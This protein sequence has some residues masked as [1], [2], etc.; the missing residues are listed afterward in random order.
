MAPTLDVYDYLDYR[1]FLRAYYEAKKAEGRGFSYRS[2]AR[3]A[4]V[5]APNHLKLVIEAQRNLAPETAVAYAEALA[6]QG[7]RG[8]YFVELVRFNQAKTSAERNAA[9]DRLTGF[10]GY[11]MAHKLDLAHAAYHAS[12]YVPAIRELA[13]REDFQAD[14]KWIAA[15]MVPAITA[16]EAK[17]ALDT[18]FELGLLEKN[19]QGRVVQGE[20]VMATGPETQGL[21]IANYHRA[22]LELAAGSIDRVHKT[23]RDISSLTMAVGPHDLH[24]LKRR[25]QRFQQELIAFA[26]KVEDADRVVQLNFQLFPLSRGRDE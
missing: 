16:A 3:R 11:R 26:T 24:E 19:E 25:L 6:L 7:D 18:L 12:W 21:H 4:G 13:C 10:R 15:Q 9:Y 8:A 22:M 14:P 17:R 23:D 2:F 1:A 20:L 5:R